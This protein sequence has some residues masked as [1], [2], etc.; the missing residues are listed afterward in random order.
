[1]K[2]MIY[3]KEKLN[4]EFLNNNNTVKNNYDN[5]IIY[6]YNKKNKDNIK[7]LNSYEEF[8]RNNNN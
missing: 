3:I 6:E 8:K 5:Q 1:M 7:I 2:N 4:K